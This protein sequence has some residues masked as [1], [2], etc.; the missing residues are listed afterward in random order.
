MLKKEGRIKRPGYTFRITTL[1]PVIFLVFKCYLLKTRIFC[2]L[3]PMSFVFHHVELFINVSSC[4]RYQ[5]SLPSL[6]FFLMRVSGTRAFFSNGHF[7]MNLIICFSNSLSCLVSA[8]E[9]EK[10]FIFRLQKVKTTCT[11]FG[12]SK[13][14][15]VENLELQMAC[16]QGTLATEFQLGDLH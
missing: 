12:L 1:S 11:D 5:P 13:Y 4:P 14:A 2:S 9:G 3:F 15:T 8:S 7:V 16:Y 6:F 10:K